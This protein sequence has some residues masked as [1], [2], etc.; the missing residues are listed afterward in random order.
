MANPKTIIDAGPLV[1]FINRRDK[2]HEWIKLQLSNR[3]PPI[4][5]P[6]R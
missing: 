2:H 1:A 6:K 3:F 4:K 5:I